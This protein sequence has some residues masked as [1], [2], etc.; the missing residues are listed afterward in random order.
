MRYRVEILR[1]GKWLDM[2]SFKTRAEAENMVSVLKEE[3]EHYT[4]IFNWNFIS[5][6][7][8]VEVKK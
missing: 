3:D 4:G 8:I 5:V 2:C 1:D 6:Y 7:R